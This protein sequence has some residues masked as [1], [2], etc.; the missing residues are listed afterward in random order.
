MN[1]LG[2]FFLDIQ[3]KKPHIFQLRVGN[4]ALSL[5]FSSCSYMY[6]TCAVHIRSGFPNLMFKEILIMAH[7]QP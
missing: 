7:K 6:C 1:A 2:G 4:F 5:F 3:L